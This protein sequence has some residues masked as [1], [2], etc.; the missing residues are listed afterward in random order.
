[1]C[2]VSC[3]TWYA[4][5]VTCHMSHVTYHMSFFYPWKKLDKVVELVLGGSV[6]N[7][8]YPVKV[9]T[10]STKIKTKTSTPY[11]F[12]TVAI[13]FLK[14]SVKNM[15]NCQIVDFDSSNEGFWCTEC[16]AKNLSSLQSTVPKKTRKPAKT[17]N[18]GH[19]DHFWPLSQFWPG[20]LDCFINSTLQRVKVFCVAFS[21]PK[22][23]IWA[24]KINNPTFF[25]FFTLRG[26][27]FDLGGLKF[28]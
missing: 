18:F 13:P 9:M 25:I 15:K 21:A 20:F 7:V 26:D 2:P 16:N 19:F 24:I 4:S 8:A 27:P 10:K 11:H 22:P 5:P 14:L 17:V 23:F 6:F 12:I 28:Y 1:M 3:V